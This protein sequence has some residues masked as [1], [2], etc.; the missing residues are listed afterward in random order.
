MSILKT[1]LD[2]LVDVVSSEAKTIRAERRADPCGTEAM[3]RDRAKIHA[4]R[5]HKV[6]ARINNRRADRWTSRCELHKEKQAADCR[7]EKQ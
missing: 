2:S 6:R 3:F 7:E 1:V 4:A 5:G